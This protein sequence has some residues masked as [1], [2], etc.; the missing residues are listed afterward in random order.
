MIVV[1]TKYGRTPL[2]L[3]YTDAALKGGGKG[4]PCNR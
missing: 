3:N 1:I 2:G 4:F